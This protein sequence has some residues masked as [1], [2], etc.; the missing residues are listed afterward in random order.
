MSTSRVN[1]VSRL[2]KA[3]ALGKTRDLSWRYNQ[4]DALERLLVV[5][6]AALIEALAKDIG[7]C[8]SEAW[9]AE[10]GYTLSD[11]KHTRKKLKLWSQPRRVSTP[12]I[13]LPGSSYVQA[14]PLGTV[15]IIGA[16][17]YP[18]QLLLGP[19]V[20]A[21][22]AGNC[23]VL[24]PSEQAPATSALLADL[25]PRYMDNDTV[26]VIEGGKEATTEL[27]GCVFD[28]VFYTGGEQVGRI[29]MRA[30]AEHLTPVT[31]ELGGK[32]PCIVDSHTHLKVTARRIVWGKWLNAGQTCIAP[33]YVLV[34]KAFADDFVQALKS[35]LISQ[36]GT[37]PLNNGDY[38][39]V[40]H[41]RHLKRLQHLLEDQYIAH[42]GDSDDEK[43]QMAPTIIMD[44]PLDSPLMTEEIFGPILPIVT[45]DS[46]TDA[47]DFVATRPKPLALYMFSEDKALQNKVLQQTSSGS[48]CVNDIMMFMM[49]PELPFGGVGSSGMGRYH[50]QWGFDTFSHLKSVMKRSFWFDFAM[51]YAPYSKR[52][53]SLLK[54]L[55]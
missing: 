32:S 11:I 2:R 7:K 8:E 33:D 48:V 12:M 6:Q 9:T 39:K 40:V 55:L 52:K 18:V 23:A 35:E 20:G 43:C 54:K 17:N 47:M 51:R 21:L 1:T 50:G 24:K 26:A 34:E 27:L 29:V 49:N 22:A 37:D 41:P 31:L 10:I 5:N 53:L 30:C 16:W 19:Y 46:I 45:L 38:G 15:L 3:F 36:Y 42:G 44:P 13:A 28:H 25:I 4:L 14:E